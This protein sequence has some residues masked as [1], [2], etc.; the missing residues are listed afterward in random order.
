[1]T[2]RELSLLYEKELNGSSSL[3]RKSLPND[4]ELQRMRR[5]GGGTGR[6]LDVSKNGEVKRETRVEGEKLGESRLWQACSRASQQSRGW[7]ER[8]CDMALQ[9]SSRVWQMLPSRETMSH[10]AKTTAILALLTS[11]ARALGQTYG[12]DSSALAVSWRD[13]NNLTDRIC[14]PPPPPVE[15][16]RKLGVLDAE[17][18]CPAVPLSPG[19]RAA[20]KSLSE[21]GEGK[22]SAPKGQTVED[23]W[24]ASIRRGPREASRKILGFLSTF[25]AKLKEAPEELL[26]GQSTLEVSRSSGDGENQGSRYAS[27]LSDTSSS[28]PLTG[29][30]TRTS[31]AVVL[32][33]KSFGRIESPILEEPDLPQGEAQGKD[34]RETSLGFRPSKTTLGGEISQAPVDAPSDRLEQDKSEMVEY[35]EFSREEPP[36]VSFLKKNEKAWQACE[37]LANDEEVVEC[38]CNLMK[39][40]GFRSYALCEMKNEESVKGAASLLEEKSQESMKDALLSLE[41]VVSSLEKNQESMKDALLSLEKAILLL[42]DE[43]CKPYR[44]QRLFMFYTDYC[45]DGK[46]ISHQDGP[47]WR[48]GWTRA[49]IV[50]LAVVAARKVLGNLRDIAN[51]REMS[52]FFQENQHLFGY[53]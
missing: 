23:S 1:M 25:R 24:L 44:V 46:G 31:D 48:I 33:P 10:V 42:R 21:Q 12:S 11:P 17:E 6:P 40:R 13:S 29:E 43:Q 34:E 26:S 36:F 35:P 3:E 20:D 47:G 28:S 38:V 53:R 8:V 51:R 39:D 18:F 22:F 9:E 19:Q 41:K 14:L 16:L 49:G 52:R 7:V 2:K 27:S 32:Q 50:L 4:N 30:T 5:N 37:E 45:R 15:L